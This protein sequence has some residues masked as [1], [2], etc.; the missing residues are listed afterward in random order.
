MRLFL[1]LLFSVLGLTTAAQAATLTYTGQ[2]FDTFGGVPNPETDRI[3]AGVDLSG[4]YHSGMSLTYELRVDGPLQA[5]TEYSN[6]VALGV[7]TTGM[8]S[9]AELISAS[10]GKSTWTGAEPS[11]FEFYVD[12]DLNVTKWNVQFGQFSNEYHV[13]RSSHA[14]GDHAE[15]RS[16]FGIPDPSPNPFPGISGYVCCGGEQLSGSTASLG[17]WSVSAQSA[18]EL[19]AVPVGPSG[20]LMLGALALAAGW[21][22]R[23]I[24]TAT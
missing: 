20:V 13:A 9:K 3:G 24:V 6:R 18:P 16:E 19:T 17:T 22:R 4:P 14:F 1:F 10:D 21:S 8:T 23:V 2:F 15:F 5:N 11:F 7:Y 12:A